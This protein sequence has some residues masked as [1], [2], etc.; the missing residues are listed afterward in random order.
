ME[1]EERLVVVFFIN[2]V[3]PFSLL[4]KYVQNDNLTKTQLKRNFKERKT[5]LLSLR[6]VVLGL[7]QEADGALFSLLFPKYKKGN[8]IKRK[9]EEEPKGRKRPT[10]H[11][12]LQPFPSPPETYQSYSNYSSRVIGG[13][14]GSR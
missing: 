6:S 2:C 10:I 9:K 5:A 7:S 13:K 4:Q 14:A 8:K 11:S 3:Y 12:P 1:V